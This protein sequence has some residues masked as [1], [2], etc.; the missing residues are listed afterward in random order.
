[1]NYNEIVGMID[2]SLL[3]P[4]LNDKEI[5]AGCKLAKEFK[6]ASVCVK[7]Y[8]IKQVCELLKDSD[9]KVGTVIGFPHGN[10][11]IATKV[12]ETT[13]AIADGAV[14]IDMVINI[15]KVLSEDYDY[16]EQEIGEIIAV[17]RKNGA[18][19][20]VIFENDFLPEDTYKIRLCE[21]CNKL[22]VD[23]VKTS[24]GY[25]FKKL[26]D[27]SYN[28]DGATDN[29]LILMRKYCLPHVKIK[30]AGGIRT[31]TDLLRVKALGV[32]RVGASATKEILNE[33]LKMNS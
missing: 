7:P 14:E 19:L 31:L 10:S 24:T 8:S 12:Y 30:A 20:K 33:L 13:Q 16:I 25:G 27:G 3:N 1:M 21:I 15:G 11:S 28:Y 29:D 32:T 22:N 26:A 9:V 23:Y 2:H 6:V 4:S 17:T 18:I 5:A